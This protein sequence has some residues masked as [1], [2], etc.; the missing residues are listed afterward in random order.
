MAASSS[1]DESSQRSVLFVRMIH[2]GIEVGVAMKAVAFWIW[3][4]TQGF[5]EIMRKILLHDD[6]FL[7]LLAKEAEDILS[8]LKQLSKN[9]ISP[10]LM[11]FTPKLAEH[12]L[13]LNVI[14][15]DKEKALKG[16][17]EIYNGVCCVVLKDILER[18]GKQITEGNVFSPLQKVKKLGSE[19]DGSRAKPIAPYAGSRLNPSAK[20]WNPVTERAAEENRCLFL[21]FSNGYPLTESQISRFFTMNYGSCVERVYVHWPEPKDQGAPPLFGKVVFTASY[22]PAMILNGKTEAKF[23]VD[24]KPLWGKR[25]KPKKRSGYK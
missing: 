11:R 5:Q 14:L 3:L 18:M 23:W 6:R 7:T 22:I 21:T 2:F 8:F 15:A 13:S 20:E 19:K 1:S 10:D 17:T 25:F 16:I 24:A 12:F 9:P 4:E